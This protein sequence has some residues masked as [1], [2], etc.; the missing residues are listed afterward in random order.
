[1]KN[2]KKELTMAT[3]RIQNFWYRK[4]ALKHIGNARRNVRYY[5]PWK[6]EMDRA[7]YFVQRQRVV[8]NKMI[9]LV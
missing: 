8:T 3:L 6:K 9:E 5:E 4:Q 7:Y 1:M 2:L